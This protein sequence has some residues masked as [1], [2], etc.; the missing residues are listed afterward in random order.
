MKKT[1]FSNTKMKGYDAA[2]IWGEKFTYVSP[3]WFTLKPGNP[4]NGQHPAKLNMVIEGGLI[5]RRRT[6]KFA[7]FVLITFFCFLF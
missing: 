2:K 6:Q 3:V 7:H 5:R 1:N 4:K